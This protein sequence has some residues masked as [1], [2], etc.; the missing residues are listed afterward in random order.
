MAKFSK[1]KINFPLIKTIYQ[2]IKGTVVYTL[3]RRKEKFKN[4]EVGQLLIYVNSGFFSYR[5]FGVFAVSPVKKSS[6]A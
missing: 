2:K 1:K 6:S 5:I 4:F 3:C